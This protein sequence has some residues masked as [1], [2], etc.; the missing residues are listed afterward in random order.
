MLISSSRK[1][2][3]TDMPR[4]LAKPRSEQTD[5]T[6]RDSWGPEPSAESSPSMLGVAFIT[7]GIVGLN[8]IAGSSGGFIGAGIGTG[9][10]AAVSYGADIGE[11]SGNTALAAVGGAAGALW[12]PVGTVAAAVVGGIAGATFYK[13]VTG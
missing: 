5:D 4:A 3:T 2:K 1:P 10:T 11:P 8:G 12:G 13:M 9:V 7:A 6:P